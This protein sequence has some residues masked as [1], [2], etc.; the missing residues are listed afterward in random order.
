[1]MPLYT[2][3]TLTGFAKIATDLTE[4]QRHA[5]ELQR[6]RD[7]LELRVVERTKELAESNSALI[8]EAEARIA[9]E[10]QRIY[11]LRRLVNSQEFERRR[12]ARDIHDQLGQRLTGLRLKLA[13]LRSMVGEDGDVAAR[14]TRLQEICERLDAEVS[15]LAWELRPTALD[16]LGLIEALRTFVHEWSRHHE[17]DAK[18]HAVRVSDIRLDSD[19]E[20]HLYRIAQEALNNIMKHADA[21]NVSVMLERRRNEVILIIEDDGSGFDPAATK[22]GNRRSG[23]GLG[24]TGMKERASLIGGNL[25][26]ESSAAGTTIYVRVATFSG[27]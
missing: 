25:E 11:L 20:T 7:Q 19:V 5:E 12:I 24:L 22:P 6:A 14:V 8:R 23:G 10:Q 16:D 4:K 17:I 13:S 3:K 27:Q 2:G 18:F 1:M 26:I 15:F 21:K 9:G